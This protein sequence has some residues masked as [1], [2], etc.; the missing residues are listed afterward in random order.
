MHWRGDC[1]CVWHPVDYETFSQAVNFE[2]MFSTL[3]DRKWNEDGTYSYQ[4]D[5]AA[6]WT[7]ADAQTFVFKLN[8][9]IK[10]HDGTPFTAQD[11]RWTINESQK[12]SPG[13]FKNDAWDAVKGGAAARDAFTKSGTEPNLEGVKVID[14]NT[15]EITIDGPNSVWLF[16]LGEPDAVV[17]PQHILK[18]LLKGVPQDKVRSTIETSAFAT[19]SPIGTGPYKFIKYETDQYSQFEAFADYFKGP[20]KIKNVFIK[21]LTDDAA[22]AAGEAGDLELSVRL[23]PAEKERLE[24]VAAL[25][26]LS[27]PGVS[28]YGPLFNLLKSKCDL[29]CRRAVSFAIDAPGIIKNIYKDGGIVN[30]GVNPGMPAADDQEYFGYDPD[31]AKA[32][33]AQS[34]WDKSQPLRIIFDTSFA[35]VKLWTPVMQQNLEAVGFKVELRGLET[36]AAIAEYDKIDAYDITVMQGGSNGVGWFVYAQ[37]HN[38]HPEK[39]NPAWTTYIIDCANIDDVF[40]KAKVEPDDAKRLELT[41]SVSKF[42]NTVVDRTSLWT[43]N[44]LSFKAKCLSG[45]VVP[46]NTR[47]FIVGVQNWF[48]TC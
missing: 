47:E 5:L 48:F 44:A 3:I 31:K 45:P 41:K 16:D 7:T 28:T 15:I 17:L 37:S 23:N 34:A 4:G 9:N 22:I 14:D 20:A 40:A 38:C 35:G 12:W 33:L 39:L 24:K 13:K 21:R 6:S 32:E 46:K 43:L 25:D 19:T 26:T 29:H 10:W 1:T 2:M 8:P 42:L 18:D 11:I 36:T 27:T 30:R